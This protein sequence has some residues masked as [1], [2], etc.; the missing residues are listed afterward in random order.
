[1]KDSEST[2]SLSNS[3]PSVRRPVC[4]AIHQSIERAGMA[5]DEFA[6]W[7]KGG[8]RR[9]GLQINVCKTPPAAPIAAFSEGSGQSYSL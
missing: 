9:G 3:A 2:E 4:R 1:M 8:E 7:R 5:M 6:N